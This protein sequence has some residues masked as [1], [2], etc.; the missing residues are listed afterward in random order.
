MKNL[1]KLVALVLVLVL[2]A[3]GCSS[4]SPSQSAPKPTEQPA[5]ESKPVSSQA[6][7]GD[8]ADPMDFS[9]PITLDVFNMGTTLSGEQ[10][11]WFG[12][13]L[14][15]RWNL[16][17]NV[18]PN[19]GESDSKYQTLA[20]S[21]NLGDVII[22]TSPGQNF[23][24]AMKAGDLLY[25]LSTDDALYNYMPYF[26]ENFPVA[27]ERMKTFSSDGGMYGIPT[28]VSMMDPTG[29]QNASEVDYG[30]MIRFDYY[31]DAGTPELNT[32][33]D[34]IPCFEAMKAAH[35]ETEEGKPTYAASLHAGMD[36]P[37]GM[38]HAQTILGLYG[39]S[40]LCS[41]SVVYVD[42][43]AENYQDVLQ[44]DGLYMR[45]LRLF[46]DLNQRGLLD[47][48]S[49]TQTNSDT[50]AKFS[51]GQVFY[52][53]W[54]WEAKN[55]FNTPENVE[56]GIGYAMAPL[57]D[58][59]ISSVGFAP[60]GTNGPVIALGAGCKDVS[61]ALTF[62]D[63]AYTPEGVMTL[64]NGPEGL[65]WEYDADGM[66]YLTDFGKEALP[67]NNVD[68]PEEWGGLGFADGFQNLSLYPL[69]NAEISPD[70]GEAYKYANWSSTLSD[71]MSNLDKK[72][73]EKMGG[74][75]YTKEYLVNNDMLSVIP[76]NTYTAPAMETDMKGTRDQVGNILKQ[77]SWQMVFAKDDAEF[78]ST[79][80]EM[81]TMAKEMGYDTLVE[82]YLSLLPETHQARV[83]A[84][85]SVK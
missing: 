71:A 24:Q 18:I 7:D 73:S 48:D 56:A 70:F 33:E 28:R 8:T 34:L 65:T 80:Q 43:M 30:I 54:Y 25:D 47:P 82:Y 16:I 38:A 52:S 67:Q 44:E 64:Y 29:S 46:Y 11:G 17:L 62:L 27:V 85:N 63:W 32:L 10:T 81:I 15:D 20:A 50:G 72:W 4:P 42:S 76:G 84:V 36:N 37:A 21:G 57:K 41:D 40:A 51:A 74:A 66:P 2:L 9:E 3:A 6:E 14:K 79:K 45:G 58:Q 19:D 77:Y 61:R 69:S 5:D 13:M 53:N 78:E 55:A 60:G 68:V 49:L 23:Q 12:K 35:P 59:K 1:S 26:V 31:L 75:R 39:Y 22:F 83:D